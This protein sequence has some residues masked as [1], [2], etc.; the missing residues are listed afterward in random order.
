MINEATGKIH[1]GLVV[2]VILTWWAVKD[3]NF[4]PMD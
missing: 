4:R 3:L 2:I 1:A